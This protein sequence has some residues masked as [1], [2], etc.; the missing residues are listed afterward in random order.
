MGRIVFL[1]GRNS[2]RRK[3]G[4]VR[5]WRWRGRGGGGER[6]VSCLGTGSLAYRDIFVGGCGDS[7]IRS[8]DIIKSFGGVIGFH[9][10]V[11]GM[12]ALSRP[13]S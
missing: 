8:H 11:D 9:G 12:L 3:G 1:W 6:R 4:R 7:Y 2:G 13:H 5:G 10:S